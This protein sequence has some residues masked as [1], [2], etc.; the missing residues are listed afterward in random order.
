MWRELIDDQAIFSIFTR[1][2]LWKICL[3]TPSNDVGNFLWIIRECIKNLYL[4]FCIVVLCTSSFVDRAGDCLPSFTIKYMCRVERFYYHILFV[5]F[6]RSTMGL[7]IVFVAW[8]N[9]AS[10]IY[11]I[12]QF[13]LSNTFSFCTFVYALV[14]IFIHFAYGNRQIINHIGKQNN[15]NRSIEHWFSNIFI[16]MKINNDE[17]NCMHNYKS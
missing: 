12:V 2:K 9:M 14:A 4:L 5:S 17:G 6:V 10:S 15:A 11:R 7:N 8:H 16:G 13:A 3:T 1:G